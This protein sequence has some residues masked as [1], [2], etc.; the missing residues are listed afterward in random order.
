MEQYDALVAQTQ[1]YIIGDTTYTLS[2][3]TM[4]DIKQLR[5][6]ARSDLMQEQLTACESSQERMEIIRNFATVP[7]EVIAAKIDSTEGQ[8][9]SICLSIAHTNPTITEGDIENMCLGCMPE[10]ALI[11]LQLTYPKI[12][13]AMNKD[14][15]DG[16]SEPKNLQKQSKKTPNM[17]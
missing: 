13:E 10:M 14:E 7:D 4:G 17:K 5:K 9:K 2:P 1:D 8:I 16:E 12:M 11:I 15:A 6:W 3:L